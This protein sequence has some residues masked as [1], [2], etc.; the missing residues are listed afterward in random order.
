MYLL[1]DVSV[2]FDNF[3]NSNMLD[4][5][6]VHQ[7]TIRNSDESAR[8]WFCNALSTLS[9]D[10]IE[11][12]EIKVADLEFSSD[13]PPSMV[14]RIVG[15]DAKYFVIK[16][17]SVYTIRSEHSPG[18]TPGIFNIS[19]II[20]W[21]ECSNQ[22]SQFLTHTVS[23][24]AK[25][26]VPRL[27]LADPV[28]SIS[29]GDS[30]VSGSQVASLVLSNNLSLS[31]ICLAGPDAEKFHIEGNK[32]FVKN[33]MFDEKMS[34]TNIVLIVA[35]YKVTQKNKFEPQTIQMS[36]V[37]MS[38]ESY[39]LMYVETQAAV[40]VSDTIL[41]LSP[42]TGVISSAYITIVDGYDKGNDFLVMVNQ[43]SEH[44]GT[45]QFSNDDQFDQY[46]D[47]DSQRG[48]LRISGEGTVSQ[49]VSLLR[50]IKYFNA[51][52]D[53]DGVTRSIEIS[54]EE[55]G[56]CSNVLKRELFV[57]PARYSADYTDS[58]N[59]F[60]DS[61]YMED[62]E[63]LI[64]DQELMLGILKNSISDK[65][66]LNDTSVFQITEPP[67]G[68]E[69]YVNNESVNTFTL[70]DISEKKVVLKHDGSNRKGGTLFL[71]VDNGDEAIFALT[72]HVFVYAEGKRNPNT[73][74][75]NDEGRPLGLAD[76]ADLDE[77]KP[78]HHYSIDK[79]NIAANT[80]F[81]LDK[82]A[83]SDRPDSVIKRFAAA[84]SPIR[85]ERKNM[86][87]WN[88]SMFQDVLPSNLELLASLQLPHLPAMVHVY[89]KTPGVFELADMI[90]KHTSGSAE[91]MGYRSELL[92]T[93]LE[94][95]PLVLSVDATLWSDWF[96]CNPLFQAGTVDL[97]QSF[98]DC[99][100]SLLG[101]SDLQSVVSSNS[102]DGVSNEFIAWLLS[103][104]HLLSVLQ[105][106]PDLYSRTA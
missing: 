93:L 85:S 46:V 54:I 48:I 84:I 72:L 96:S 41:A 18:I 106:H 105:T 70:Q 77:T 80:N 28:Q 71:E 91:S 39:P 30:S 31:E 1:V 87:F 98:E 69:I 2:T 53:I 5:L 92:T 19:L 14:I 95:N 43:S 79:S 62:F 17:R 75:W 100:A 68:I 40:S 52:D 86:M 26:E 36:P 57:V 94:L 99:A 7:I 59:Q 51:G 60:N 45:T 37:L 42:G 3:E 81:H 11:H 44:S 13:V 32:V 12:Q 66:Q 61:V 104:G 33:A 24:F 23:I 82:R 97:R 29:F 103:S 74:S 102:A 35:A 64:F 58:I 10:L 15:E 76:L 78:S 22:E 8:V 101:E 73:V 9:L 88:K 20:D 67:P 56:I 27:L 21:P 83:G 47:F 25:G 90:V 6:A 38:I 55:A 34:S 4:I 65:I 63:S 89:Q 49:Y 16:G 50:S